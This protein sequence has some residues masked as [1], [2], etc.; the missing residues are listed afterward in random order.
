M[1]V[2]GPNQKEELLI[3]NAV[4]TET[5]VSTFLA[6]ASDKELGVF[7]K[8]GADVAEGEKFYVL[9]KTNGPSGAFKNLDYEF[10]DAIIPSMV[11]SVKLAPYQAEVQK[12]VTV[13][14]FPATPVQNATYEVLVRL[15]NDGGALSTENFRIISGFY[16]TDA[17]IV[18]NANIIDGLVKA[19]EDNQKLEGDSLFTFAN[20]G[21]RS[22]TITSKAQSG[23][24]AKNIADQIQF[25]VQVAI[26]SNQAD[27]ITGVYATY[28][29]L[30]ATVT[31]PA[32]P[33]TGTGKYVSNLEWFT[34]GYNYEAYRETGYP[35]NFS[36]PALYADY[37]GAYNIIHI[38]HYTKN[39]VVGVEEQPRTLTLAVA[40][41]PGDVATNAPTNALLA[42]LRT[43]LGTDRVPADLAVI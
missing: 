29:G 7:S 35:A 38:D 20:V 41:T 31:T 2:F 9:Q 32:N 16:V 19:L 22:L 25:D 5:T 1:A 4:A 39:S 3:G 42:K 37:N 12:L 26:K 13:S 10:S 21:D 8:N 28:S 36:Q 30:V 40:F 23:D 15:Y 14:G 18:T 34:R 33:G 27:P 24:P 43:A 11:K 6:S 17:S